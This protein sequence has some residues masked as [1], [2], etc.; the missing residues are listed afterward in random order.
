[1][2]NENTF[3]NA[4]TTTGDGTD[5]F[6][7]GM[8]TLAVNIQGTSSS[9]TVEFYASYDGTTY[10]PI[11]GINTN[12]LTTGVSTTGTGQTWQFD[13]SGFEKFRAKIT[14]IAGGNC[15]IKGR[16]VS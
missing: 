10:N 9:R 14:A 2:Y 5:M 12:G 3:H 8:S 15:T 13:V 1:M 7:N 16:A 6:V 4:V 11:T